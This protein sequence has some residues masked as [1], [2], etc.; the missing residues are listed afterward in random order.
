MNTQTIYEILGQARLL[1][2]NEQRE[3]NRLLCDN[4]K[5]VSRIESIK[6]A[7]QFNIGDTVVFDAGRKGIIKCMINGFSRDGAKIKGTQIGGLRPGCQWTATANLC[8]KAWL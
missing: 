6:V 7:N 8:K 1:T 5:R 2:L 3:L 4:M